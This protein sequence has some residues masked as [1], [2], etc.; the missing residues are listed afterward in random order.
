MLAIQP[1]LA[2]LADMA[3]FP[4]PPASVVNTLASL[5][6]YAGLHS[7][8]SMFESLAHSEWIRHALGAVTSQIA[9]FV[10]VAGGHRLLAQAKAAYR[11]YERGDARPLKEFISKQLRFLDRLDD[12]CQ[13]LALALLTGDWKQ[14]IDTSDAKAVRRALTR[15][16]REGNDLES[17]HQ[18]GKRPIGYYESWDLNLRVPGP[19]LE[20]LVINQVLPWHETFE[21]RRVRY[22]V[23]KLRPEEREIARAWA[24]NPPITWN[25]APE[26]VDADAL[27]GDRV[28]RKVRRLGI[29]PSH[30][31]LLLQEE[32]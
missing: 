21:D 22:T 23:G 1:S 2:A 18:A 31:E 11:A 14:S 10:S 20:D 17:D 29:E 26:L 19:G 12:R 30:H 3:H 7:I 9:E 8:Q 4:F 27:A 5:H 16:A 13:A 25:R 32:A 28:R 15:A 24:E 6:N